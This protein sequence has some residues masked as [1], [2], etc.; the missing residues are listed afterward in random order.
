[1]YELYQQIEQKIAH[2][3]DAGDSDELFSSGYLTGHLSLALAHCE[4][5][6]MHSAQDFIAQVEQE[7]A[8]A[9]AARELN[10]ADQILVET[11]W[12]R[13]IEG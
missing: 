4:Q 11:M 2:I 1:M 7:M 6:D 12:Q 3:L 10:P 5:A 8:Q 13:L 9:F